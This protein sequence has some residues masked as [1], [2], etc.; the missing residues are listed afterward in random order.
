MINLEQKE[1][2]IS[3]VNEHH[4]ACVLLLDTSGSM[5]NNG[6]INKLNEGVRKFKEQTM[7]DEI[8]QK[9]VDIAIVEFNTDAHIVQD[10]IPLAELEVPVLK[11]GGSTSLGK[12]LEYAMELVEKRK[13]RYKEIGV[14]YY[15]SWIFIISDGEPTDDYTPAAVKAREMAEKNKFVCWAVGVPGYSKK[16]LQKVTDRL[17]ELTDINFPTIFEWLSNSLVK[18]SNSKGMAV[19]YPDLPDNGRVIPKDW[20]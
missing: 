19:N 3:A 20:D 14:P 15:R 1:F 8:A 4:V 5:S 18:V 17:F 12:G 7:L 10:F 11:A 13:A 16:A 2:N 6:A 9:C